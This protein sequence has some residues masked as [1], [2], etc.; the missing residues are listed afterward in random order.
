[1]AQQNKL[2]EAAALPSSILE[3]SIPNL[4]RDTDYHYLSFYTFP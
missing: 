4:G 2:L 1:M 3:T